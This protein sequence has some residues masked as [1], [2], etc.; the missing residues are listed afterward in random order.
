MSESKKCN[1][2][3]GDINEATGFCMNCV[4]PF[5]EAELDCKKKKRKRIPFKKNNGV[6]HGRHK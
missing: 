3:Q 2:C 5:K 4:R 1:H 6:Q